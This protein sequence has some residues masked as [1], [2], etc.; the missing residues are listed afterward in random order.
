[1]REYPLLRSFILAKPDPP[2][3]RSTACEVVTSSDLDSRPRLAM[4]NAPEDEVRFHARDAPYESLLAS[5]GREY[6]S[7]LGIS[8]NSSRRKLDSRRCAMA[9]IHPSVRS[10]RT[11]CR[12]RVRIPAPAP[13]IGAKVADYTRIYSEKRRTK[14]AYRRVPRFS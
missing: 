9:Q 12:D 7:F 8:Q 11:W 4:C 14:V 1:M 6:G 2:A 5:Q 10:L 3:A 13:S